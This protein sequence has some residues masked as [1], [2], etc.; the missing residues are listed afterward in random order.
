MQHGVP[1]TLV[2]DN[3]AGLLMGKAGSTPSS[4]A[5]TAS[6]PTGR[7]Q[8][9]RHLLKAPG[10]LRQRRPLLRRRPRLDPRLRLPRRPRHFPSRSAR[11]TNSAWSAASTTRGTPSALRQ[12]PEEEAVGNPAFDVTPGPAGHRPHHRAGRR[13]RQRRRTGRPLPGSGP[14]QHRLAPV[15]R[16]GAKRRRCPVSAPTRPP[17]RSAHPPA[18]G[19]RAATG[20]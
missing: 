18:G 11:A 10:L 2:A 16:R 1:H 8:Q 20:G 3:A 17:A 12:L 4:S 15:G 6:P 19:C 5:P 9:G 13:H 14:L 7:R